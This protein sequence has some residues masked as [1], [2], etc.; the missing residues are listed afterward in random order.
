[1]L[2]RGPGGNAGAAEGLPGPRERSFKSRE[3]EA[4]A[5]SP[6][7]LVSILEFSY[8]LAKRVKG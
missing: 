7:F 5:E 6:C 2:T 8:F 3:W 1:M 4:H